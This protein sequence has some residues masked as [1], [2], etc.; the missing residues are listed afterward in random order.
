MYG[1]IVISWCC[2]QE[3]D[4]LLLARFVRGQEFRL[5]FRH[6]L[7]A[8]GIGRSEARILQHR[9]ERAIAAQLDLAERRD[10]TCIERQ[11]Q[12]TL[13]QVVVG[14]LA[15]RLPLRHACEAGVEPVGVLVQR[16]D[17]IVARLDETL[18][19]ARR[20]LVRQRHQARG[21]EIVA[22]ARRLDRELRV[23]LHGLR[24]IGA[25]S[26]QHRWHLLQARRCGQCARSMRRVVLFQQREQGIRT[27][28]DVGLRVRR[29]RVEPA[30]EEV[31]AFELR[32]EQ[33]RIDAIVA[34]PA[35]GRHRLDLRQQ[36]ADVL[37]TRA[38]RLRRILGQAVVVAMIAQRTRC[39]GK[40]DVAPLVVVVRELAQLCG[41]R[42]GA[43]RPQ[44]G[45]GGEEQ[46]DDARGK[47]HVWT[48][49]DRAAIVTHDVTMGGARALGSTNDEGP[50]CIGR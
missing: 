10:V 29:D 31:S 16:L 32:L 50:K 28:V 42:S 18:A 34:A 35:F 46:A 25:R 39:H 17:R 47:A 15:D 40:G 43:Q 27:L 5:I 4:D 49:A 21:V 44:R 12:H 1:G 41:V 13:Q 38:H 14:L 24:Q 45:Q 20:Q 7:R 48:S 3:V 2:F 37:A 23:Q 36:L 8:S 19:L 9:F 6:A 11:Q 26:S 22:A 30:A 33:D